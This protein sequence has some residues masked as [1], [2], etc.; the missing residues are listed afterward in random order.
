MRL[1][2]E[3]KDAI[4]NTIRLKE[5]IGNRKIDLIITET[6]RTAFEKYAYKTRVPQGD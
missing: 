4:V 3:Q 5:K 2:K 6:P 1:D